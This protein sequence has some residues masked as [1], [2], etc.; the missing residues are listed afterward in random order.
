MAEYFVHNGV[1]AVAVSSGESGK[2]SMN[3]EEALN[4][5]NK[6]E[7]QVIFS[8]DMFN[9]GLDIPGIDK[10]MF[11]RPTESPTV[12][13]QQ[14]GRGLRKSKDKE[15]LNVLDFIGNYKKADLIPFLLSGKIYNIV[16]AKKRSF[17]IY[18]IY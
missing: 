2:Y 1:K 17:K 14:L 13:L 16:A 7:I 12:F 8:V 6:G 4:D 9:Q 3:S 15:Y 18:R 10:V 5:L 11:L